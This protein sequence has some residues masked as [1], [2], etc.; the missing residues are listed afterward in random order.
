MEDSRACDWRCE[1][2]KVDCSRGG[3][4]SAGGGGA[5]HPHCFH[6]RP[7]GASVERPITRKTTAIQYPSQANDWRYFVCPSVFGA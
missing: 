6:A 3:K 5:A 7:I 4:L 2:A 1:G